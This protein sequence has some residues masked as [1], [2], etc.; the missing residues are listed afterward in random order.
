MRRRFRVGSMMVAG[1]C[2]ASSAALAQTGVTKDEF[3][4]ES[5]AGKALSKFVASK[6]KCTSKC[7][8]GARKT[9]GP[10]TDCFAPFGGATATCIQ[11]P[12]KG[13]EAKARASIVKKC[14]KDCPECYAASVCST[15]EPFVATTE[16]L[17]D[18]QGPLVYCVENGGGT[19]T[20]TEA[21]CEDG[22]SKAL[23][24]FVANKSKCYDKCN[25]NIFKGK[26]PEGSCDP[27]TPSDAATL[28]CVMD[29]VKGAEAKAIKAIDKVCSAA[30]ANPACYVPARDTGAEWVAAVEPVIDSQIPIIACGSPSAAFVD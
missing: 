6:S 7:L 13:A 16:T 12:V 27:P 8:T 17:I 29:P 18:A 22:V 9:S 30:G 2:L 26:I 24:K 21:K 25:A 1:L 10:Y 15:G 28:A 19:P 14:T 4:C 11:D 23:V 5:N 3:K 20:K